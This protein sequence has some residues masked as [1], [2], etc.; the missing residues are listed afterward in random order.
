MSQ[1]LGK[2][3]VYIYI[4]SLTSIVYQAIFAY[5]YSFLHVSHI[6]AVTLV[7]YSISVSRIA[8]LLNVVH[9]SI[10]LQW[11]TT[12]DTVKRIYESITGL[13]KLRY[14]RLSQQASKAW[15]NNYIP[16]K[17]GVYN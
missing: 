10:S 3:T 11:R 12:Y 7:G 5:R 1:I 8:V 4:E 2:D 13:C 17:T 9:M 6:V 14:A 16:Q 15:I